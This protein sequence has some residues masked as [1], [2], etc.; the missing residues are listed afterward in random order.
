MRVRPPDQAQCAC[1]AVQVGHGAGVREQRWLGA[2]LDR[3]PRCQQQRHARCRRDCGAT[4]WAGVGRAAVHRQS[5]GGPVCVVWCVGFQPACVGCLP[6]WYVHVVPGSGVGRRGAKNRP[7]WYRAFSGAKGE[8]RG[9]FVTQGV[10]V[11]VRLPL[12][13]KLR[14]H[15]RRAGCQRGQWASRRTLET[16]LPPASIYPAWQMNYDSAKLVIHIVTSGRHWS[17]P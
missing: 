8:C 6:G 15:P 7:E 13:V 2:G 1:G 16:T 3:V 17:S 11:V 5:S 12:Q 9:L 10:D 4:A 14:L